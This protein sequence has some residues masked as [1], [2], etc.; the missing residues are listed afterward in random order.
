MRC[1]EIQY[2]EGDAQLTATMYRTGQHRHALEHGGVPRILLNGAVA[3]GEADVS[4]RAVLSG[5]QRRNAQR[6]SAH[7]KPDACLMVYTSGTT[8]RPKGGLRS[9]MVYRIG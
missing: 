7:T 2:I 5:L 1:S 4:H 3:D 9:V 8:G 6:S